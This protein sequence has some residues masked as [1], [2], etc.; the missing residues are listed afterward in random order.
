MAFSKADQFSQEDIELSKIAKALAHPARIS[1]VKLLANKNACICNDI[2]EELPLSQSTVSQHLKE[3]RS[4]GVVKGDVDGPRVCYCLDW[5]CLQ[6]CA[7][8]FFNFF[9]KTEESG[10]SCC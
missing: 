8:L 4:A 10:K 1:I 2:V 5:N 9:K 7:N 6:K 3:L